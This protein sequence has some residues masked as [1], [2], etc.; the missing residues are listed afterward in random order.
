[1]KSKYIICL[2]RFSHFQLIKLK[3]FWRHYLKVRLISTLN[4]FATMYVIEAPGNL[5]CNYFH[6][7]ASVIWNIFFIFLYF[8]STFQCVER[9]I[10]HLPLRIRILKDFLSV[11]SIDKQLMNGWKNACFHDEFELNEIRLVKLSKCRKKKS[12]I[13]KR[14]N[15]V[16]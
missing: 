6:A 13:M 8:C 12:R 11:N 14:F 3:I 9:H 1:M 5:F 16:Q 4:K 2:K 15:L 7:N 10:S